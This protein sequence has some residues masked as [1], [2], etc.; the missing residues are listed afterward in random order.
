MSENETAPEP[1]TPE[2]TA[3]PATP[4][5]TAAPAMP[6]PTAAPATAAPEKK[7]KLRCSCGSTR[8]KKSASYGFIGW[9]LLLAGATPEPDGVDYHCTRCGKLVEN[10]GEDD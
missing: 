2:P 3:A 9:V 4:E 5:P 1:A 6:E 7:R 8:M 10:D